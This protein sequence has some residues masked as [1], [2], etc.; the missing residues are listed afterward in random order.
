MTMVKKTKCDDGKKDEVC[1][2]FKRWHRW[3]SVNGFD[4]DI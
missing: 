2:L 4:S 3:R 1:M